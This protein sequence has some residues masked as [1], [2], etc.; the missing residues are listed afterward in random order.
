MTKRFLFLDRSKKY[1][2]LVPRR[3]RTHEEFAN[4]ICRIREALTGAT[5]EGQRASQFIASQYYVLGWVV[6]DATKHLGSRR[7]ISVQFCLQLTRK[8]PENVA[9][10]DYVMDCL[11]MLGI[12]C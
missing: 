9:L 6:G 11:R 1:A 3:V 4:S 8:H 10:G 5:L 2:V 12:T 7:L